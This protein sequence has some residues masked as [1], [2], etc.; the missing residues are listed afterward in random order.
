VGTP[1]RN[2]R[3]FELQYDGVEVL[4]HRQ[5]D[6]E[7]TTFHT[8]I[9]AV[10][11]VVGFSETLDK[12]GLPGRVEEHVLKGPKDYRV[13][14][15]I[16]QHCHY[17]PTYDSYQAYDEDIGEDG[18][19]LVPAG[20][21]PFYEF[22]EVLAGYENAFYQLKDHTQEVEHLLTVMTEVQR[23]RLWP[24]V[25][26]SPAQLLLHGSHLSSQLTP[27]ALFEKYILPYYTEFL[28]LLHDRGK[29][30][31]MHADAD[32]SRI[33]D[34]IE[35]TGWDMVE[36][37][38][39]APMVP[40]TLAQ[41]RQAWGN[42]VIIWGGLPSILLAPSM[43]EEE[44]QAYVD[45]LFDVIAPGDAFILGVADNVMPDSLIGRIAWISEEVERRGWYPTGA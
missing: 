33:L 3:I 18:L 8:P 34:L 36:C 12:Q 44:F 2:G 23:E 20:E 26:D 39:S 6:K 42:R 21:N 40:V 4:V 19:P 15:W 27:P 45:E 30:V 24:V 25:A 37:F 32:T 13:W 1:A 14:E 9:G 38:V 5:A 28:P 43:P 29:W 22:L 41:A 17:V 16:V 11:Q 35:R 31:A 7:I 10:R